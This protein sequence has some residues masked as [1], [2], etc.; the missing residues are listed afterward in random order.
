MATAH[1]KMPPPDLAKILVKILREK[2]S[3]EDELYGP[4][5]PVHIFKLDM[6]EMEQVLP[7]VQENL[8]A[9]DGWANCY[10]SFFEERRG[11]EHLGE[12]RLTFGHLLYDYR[13]VPQNLKRSR[14]FFREEKEQNMN[15]KPPK[16]LVA[17]LGIEKMREKLGISSFQMSTEEWDQVMR[18]ILAGQIMRQRDNPPVPLGIYQ[19]GKKQL[20]QLEPQHVKEAKEKKLPR[21]KGPESLKATVDFYHEAVHKKNIQIKAGSVEEEAR[22]IQSVTAENLNS[23]GISF[24]VAIRNHLISPF[25]TTEKMFYNTD[26]GVSTFTKVPEQELR[27]LLETELLPNPEQIVEHKKEILGWHKEKRKTQCNNGPAQAS[28]NGENWMKCNLC[29]IISGLEFSTSHI[30]NHHQSLHEKV[31]SFDTLTKVPKLEKK[32]HRSTAKSHWAWYPVILI[33]HRAIDV[34]LAGQYSIQPRY[35][36][37]AIKPQ[38]KQKKNSKKGKK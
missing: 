22:C 11:E 30:K 12:I 27:D 24:S 21:N 17:L 36:V 9:E 15:W 5:M 23:R 29:L 25:N 34:E 32:K 3:A 6:K 1:G 26:T 2:L 37:R 8:E 10:K 4:S 7:K 18:N 33:S 31:I 38:E 13:S 16:F 14:K 19:W 35:M 28:E 20:K